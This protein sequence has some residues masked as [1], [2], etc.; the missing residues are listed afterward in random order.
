MVPRSVG[1]ETYRGSLLVKTTKA[2]NIHA[3]TYEMGIWQT[4]TT[5][6]GIASKKFSGQQ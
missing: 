2:Q 4:V 5:T 6:M 1:R 3:D